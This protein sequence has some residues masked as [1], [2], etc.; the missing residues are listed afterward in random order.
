LSKPRSFDRNY[1]L[2]SRNVRDGRGMVKGAEAI[3]K[4]G[5][6]AVDRKTIPGERTGITGGY[7]EIAG[8]RGADAHA[9]EGARQGQRI[10]PGVGGVVCPEV[11]G[12]PEYPR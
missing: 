1:F 9:F 3:E 5:V 12:S 10:G 8:S 7:R 2:Y 6:F 11:C 4:K